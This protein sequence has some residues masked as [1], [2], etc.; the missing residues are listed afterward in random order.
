MKA[1]DVMF[2]YSR[3]SS[4]FAQVLTQQNVV[5]PAVR[6]RCSQG[7]IHRSRGQGL[8]VDVE[9]IGPEAKA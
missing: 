6:Q 4:S 7:Q 1:Q 3:R 8:N 2:S 9:A 5:F